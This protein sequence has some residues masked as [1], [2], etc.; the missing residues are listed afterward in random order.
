MCEIE[1][2]I[3]RIVWAINN[4]KKLKGLIL[5]Q[6]QVGLKF[7]KIIEGHTMLENRMDIKMSEI[8][9]SFLRATR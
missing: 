5:K 8:E 6:F 9:E 7:E 4:A 2:I 3:K 1:R